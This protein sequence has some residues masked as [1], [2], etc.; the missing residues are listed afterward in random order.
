MKPSHSRTLI[1]A[2]LAAVVALTL[3]TPARAA[4]LTNVDLTSR[5]LGAGADIDGLQVTDVGGIVV[6][7]GKTSFTAKAENA[8]RIATTFGYGR[9][10]NLIQIIDPIDDVAIQHQAERRL[11][12]SRSLDG[13]QFSVASLQGV[14][15]V[16]GHVQNAQQID[17]AIELLRGIDGVRQVRSSLER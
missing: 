2:T 1:L 13:C 11:T 16:A 4:Q 9:V 5:F 14:V 6:I 12:M 10:A 3:I 8:G 15:H 17:A 7:R